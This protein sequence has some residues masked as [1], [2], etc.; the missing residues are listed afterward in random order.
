MNALNR[1]DW[2]GFDLSRLN[3]VRLLIVL[4]IAFGYTSTMPLGPDHAEIGVHLGYDPSW[5]GIQLLFFFSG[6]LA[7]RSLR[8]HG[9]SFEYLRSRF[10]RNVPLLMIFTLM[11]V[12]VIYPLLGVK[13]DNPGDLVKK[14]GTY[15]FETVTCLNPGQPLPG[16]LDNARYMCLIQGAVWTF[17]WGMIAHIATAIGHKIGLFKSD[18]FILVMAAGVTFLYFALSQLST[19]GGKDVPNLLLTGVHLAFPFL[20]GMAAYAYRGSFP[21]RR[22]TQVATLLALGST[23]VIWFL[24]LRWSPAI[25]LLLTAF[26]TYA[27][28]LILTRSSNQKS[29]LSF[30]PDLTLTLYLIMWPT[31][32]LLLL[33]FPEFGPWQLIGLS[34]PLSLGLAYGVNRWVNQPIQSWIK[35]RSFGKVT[36]EPAAL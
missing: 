3:F 33:I 28:W 9:S 26:W 2:D 31:A 1:T 24:F 7:L 17:R 23:S 4:A 20:C 18:R 35:N 30:T 6:V 10:F 32:Q 11:T 16:L 12:L 25:E 15:F 19:W 14:L 5:I 13:S 36:V 29:G 34:L 22:T 21:K 8:R 27:A